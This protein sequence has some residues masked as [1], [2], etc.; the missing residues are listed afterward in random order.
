MMGYLMIANSRDVWTGG[1]W[2]GGAKGWQRE[3]RERERESTCRER[4]NQPKKKGS[5]LSRVG[6]LDDNWRCLHAPCRGPVAVLA[7]RGRRYRQT[8]ARPG[9]AWLRCQV[10]VRGC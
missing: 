5:L 6:D 4:A 8:L 2:A 9:P 1:H 7:L 3:E 10:R